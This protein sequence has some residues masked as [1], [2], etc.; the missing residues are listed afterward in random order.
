MEAT[1]TTLDVIDADEHLA[2]PIEMGEIIHE[3]AAS[4][5]VDERHN[6]LEE[7]RRDATLY[8]EVSNAL[9]QMASLFAA[10][11]VTAQDD[12]EE[13]ASDMLARCVLD[14]PVV[15]RLRAYY[16]KKFSQEALV[17][18]G[19]RSDSMRTHQRIAHVRAE[20]QALCKDDFMLGDVVKIAERLEDRAEALSM[21]LQTLLERRNTARF[22]VQG[23]ALRLEE[24]AAVNG[25]MAL[26]VDRAAGGSGKDRDV[27]LVHG[28]VV[29]L[30][31]LMEARPVVALR[32]SDKESYAYWQGRLE[33]VVDEF[34]AIAW[35][36]DGIVELQQSYEDWFA[37]VQKH[38]MA[39]DREAPALLEKLDKHWGSYCESQ[40]SH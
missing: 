21:Y 13:V 36:N 6:F 15:R 8:A 20:F 23:M 25:M 2:R 39:L 37:R 28:Y 14:T 22:Q 31:A 16:L 12:F 40:R 19:V 29:D 17:T 18:P 34:N 1:E 5:S 38:E 3:Y 24:V 32:K 9:T 7:L 35:E 30:Q 4:L 10:A 27:R 33:H 11:A 26:F